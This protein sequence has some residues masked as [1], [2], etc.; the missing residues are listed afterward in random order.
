MARA[1]TSGDHAPAWLRWVTRASIVVGLVALAVTVWAVG[2]ETLADHLRAIGPWFLLLLAIEGAST[3]CEAGSTY[4]MTRGTGGPTFRK[5]CVA[6]FAGRAVNS[7]TPGA[8]VGEALKVSLLARDCSTQRIVAGV[9]YTALA[10]GIVAMAI[11]AAG[12]LLTALAFPIPRAAMIILVITGV[13]ATAIAGSLVVLVRRG[14]LGALAR[15]ARRFRLISA[16]R[17]TA[18]SAKLENLDDRL[19]GDI[20]GQH[21]MAATSLVVVAQVLQR[22]AVCVTIF[23]TGYSLGIPQLIAILSA[24]VLLGWLCNIVPLGIGVAEG[25]NFALFAALGAPP[26]L[27]VALALAKRVNQVVFAALGFGVLAADRL[28][29]KVDDEIIRLPE[30]VTTTQR[31]HVMS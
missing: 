14:M 4:M 19:R 21:R 27:G 11:V 31:V 28:A 29:E 8:S 10:S 7:V 3:F 18:W 20:Q 2:V 25:G 5:V 24:G 13:I 16:A 26:S 1:R 17:L 9:M 12:S 23:A 15:T 30:I 6:Q 22:G